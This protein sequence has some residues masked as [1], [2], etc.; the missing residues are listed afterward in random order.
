MFQFTAEEIN[1]IQLSLWVATIGMA[2]SLPF[3]VLAA[4]A[5]ARWRFPCCRPS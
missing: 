5:L 1:A 2:A 4:Y 3:G